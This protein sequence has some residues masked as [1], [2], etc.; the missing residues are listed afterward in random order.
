MGTIETPIAIQ[1]E[2]DTAIIR[3]EPQH[4]S[5]IGRPRVGDTVEVTYIIYKDCKFAR[6]VR[7]ITSMSRYAHAEYVF[8][9]LRTVGEYVVAPVQRLLNRMHGKP[10]SYPDS[11]SGVV[12]AFLKESLGETPKTIGEMTPRRNV[13]DS[14]NY[15]LM[16]WE[17][18]LYPRITAPD[19][20]CGLSD[21]E[22]SMLHIA[23]GFEITDVVTE[24]NRAKV[25][26]LFRRFGF[27]DKRAFTDEYSRL[28][29]ITKDQPEITYFLAKPAASWRIVGRNEEYVSI[30]SAIKVLRCN[31]EPAD[32]AAGSH[33]SMDQRKEIDESLIILEKEKSL[34]K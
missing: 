10:S 33:L 6:I 22:R 8:S 27:I 21:I 18:Q 34:S 16:S 15:F 11:P 25:K 20:G 17:R 32:S 24:N 23:T 1:L 30:S 19:P 7:V 13:L 5:E 9:F 12:E 26:V 3:G 28:L 31:V 14:A 4:G 2:N 29:Q